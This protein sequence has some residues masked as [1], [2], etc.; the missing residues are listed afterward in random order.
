MLETYNKKDC[1]GCGIYTI[2]CPV[3]AIKMVEDN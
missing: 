3:N 2:G 1:N